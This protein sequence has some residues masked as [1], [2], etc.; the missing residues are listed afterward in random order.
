MQIGM[1]SSG[2]PR[3]LWHAGFSGRNFSID[4]QLYLQIA[5]MYYHLVRMLGM[6]LV[7]QVKGTNN[8]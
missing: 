6:C 7:F 2:L 5:H 3:S 1:P 8:G 4:E